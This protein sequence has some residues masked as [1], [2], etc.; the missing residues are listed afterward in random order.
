MRRLLLT[1]LFPLTMLCLLV[2]A[3]AAEAM[4]DGRGLYG[5]TNDQVVTNAGFILIV[6]FPIFVIVMS[7]L[8]RQLEKRKDARQA[9][10]KAML[11]DSRWHGGW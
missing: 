9:A 3:P 2:L 8:Q 6:F 10:Q 1:R 7:T 4:N 5:E 11:D